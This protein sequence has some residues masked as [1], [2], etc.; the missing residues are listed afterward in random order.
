MSMQ[1]PVLSLAMENM[2][3]MYTKKTMSLKWNFVD[4]FHDTGA[5]I[6]YFEEGNT[7]M[8]FVNVVCNT[9]HSKLLQCV[10]NS[11][12]GIYNCDLVIGEAYPDI[13]KNSTTSS[14]S[15]AVHVF[16]VTTQVMVRNNHPMASYLYINFTVYFI[17]YYH[18]S[19]Q[20]LVNNH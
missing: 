20:L 10:H 4:H 3:R 15:I 11:C 8:L 16:T 17:T 5:L 19:K 1:M 18:N 14:E 6:N 9:S 13:P 12:N 7:S 2:V